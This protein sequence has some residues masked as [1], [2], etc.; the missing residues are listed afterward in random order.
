M[1]PDIIWML[2]AFGALLMAVFLPEE[3]ELAQ[4]FLLWFI[5]MDVMM[6]RRKMP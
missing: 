3:Q 2:I 1:I 4:T 6:I 5:T